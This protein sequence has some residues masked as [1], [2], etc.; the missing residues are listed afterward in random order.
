MIPLPAVAVTGAPLAIRIPASFPSGGTRY[1]IRIANES[2]YQCTVT[3]VA[4]SISLEPYSVDVLEPSQTVTLLAATFLALSTL[5]AA[6]VSQLVVTLAEVGEDF[7]GSYP[8]PLPRQAATFSPGPVLQHITGVAGQHQ[9]I[10]I[11]IPAG[12]QQIGWQ[13]D[14]LDDDGLGPTSVAI[15]GDQSG[16][17]YGTWNFPFLQP[18]YSV[19]LSPVDTSISV[20]VFPRTA[21]GYGIYVLAWSIGMPPSNG[22][23]LWQAANLR[24]IAIAATLTAGTAGRL[25]LLGGVA[26]Q[27][28]YMHSASLGFDAA[29]GNSV[30]L[31]DG[32]PNLT[33][34]NF[35]TFEGASITPQPQEYHGAPLGRG[36]GLYLWSAVAVTVRGTA[37]VSQG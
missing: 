37:V 10:D 4:K 16:D 22:A 34:Q 12:T 14:G 25:L 11:P 8:M 7:P 27:V 1:P 29:P 18:M 21:H 5:P 2:P 36:N 33:G 26:G 35:A 19:P 30:S 6:P 31:S 15:V 28:I 17:S 13:V 23:A 20:T 3:A 32:D 24:P 9:T